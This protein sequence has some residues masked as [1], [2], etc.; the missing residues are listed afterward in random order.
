MTRCSGA[1]RS[2]KDVGGDVDH[3]GNIRLRDPCSVR[4]T[5]ACLDRALHCVVKCES[6]VVV[7]FSFI[8]L[9]CNYTV[10][11]INA[12]L[13]RPPQ[14]IMQVESREHHVEGKRNAVIPYRSMSDFS[15][16]PSWP[17]HPSS[18]PFRATP[19]HGSFVACLYNIVSIHPQPSCPR[20]A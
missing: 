10:S 13:V 8:P 18:S 17:F 20:Y 6:R 3:S 1:A 14:Q 19:W 15:I 4:R 2:S 7:I 16:S 11:I 9:S 5:Y 12:K